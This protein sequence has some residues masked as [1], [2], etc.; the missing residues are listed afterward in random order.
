MT[1]SAWNLYESC[2][3]C[4]FL[5]VNSS[6]NCTCRITGICSTHFPVSGKGRM[7]EMYVCVRLRKNCVY[8]PENQK[9]GMQLQ[10]EIWHVINL[11]AFKIMRFAMNECQVKP[12]TQSCLPPWVTHCEY[13]FFTVSSVRFDE[14]VLLPL[15]VSS[16][17]CA[18]LFKL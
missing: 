13:N 18:P 1:G 4:N 3:A 2:W 6:S 10:C 16:T 9:R 5:L 8:H 12:S 14:S 7:T 17:P 11:I 15:I